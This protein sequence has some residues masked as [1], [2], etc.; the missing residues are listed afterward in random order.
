MS[1]SIWIVNLVVLAAV[2]A[3]DL[4]TREITRRRVVRPLIVSGLAVA[5][6]VKS[7]QTSGAGLA[8]E[9]V[10]LVAG[11]ALGMIGSRLFMVVRRDEDSNTATSI[12]GVGYAAFWLVVIAARLLFSYGANHWF[13][14][15][16]GQWLA[17][18]QITVA[19]LTDA[20]ILLAIGL[21]LARVARFARVLSEVG[22]GGRDRRISRQDRR[23]A[24]RLRHGL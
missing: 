20:L 14:H 10:G 4:G 5:V 23:L 7:P 11:L 19:G 18:H 16:L 17:A 12:A 24:R 21:V 3:A 6:F 15:P 8:I 1:A 9:V 13:S 2:L 22:D